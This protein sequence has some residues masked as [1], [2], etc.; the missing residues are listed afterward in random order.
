MRLLIAGWRG[1]VARALAEIAP[2]CAD[3]SALAVGRAA[4][5]LH[6]PGSVSRAIADLRPDVVI[7]SAAYTGV[8]KAESEPDAAFRL[9]ADGAAMLASAAARHGAAIIH[10]STDYVFDGSK[11]GAWIETDPTS[12]VNVYGRSRLAG[13]AAVIAANRRHLVVRT[14]WLYGPHGRNFAKTVTQLA[15]D[16]RAELRVVSDHLGSPTYAPHLAA[17]IL[18]LARRAVSQPA[19]TPWGVYHA[20]GDGAASWYALAGEIMEVAARLGMP[21]VP[22]VSIPATQY[23]TVARRIANARL[24]CSKLQRTFGLNL[25]DWRHGVSECTARLKERGWPAV[26]NPVET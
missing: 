20:A 9:N 8:D 19:A 25:P 1:Q 5:D 21:S 22:V 12:P 4:L 16:G 23:P 14:S 7:N 26:S 18:E 3:I 2:S 24:D 6:D 11:A 10:V 15:G 17:I 13:E